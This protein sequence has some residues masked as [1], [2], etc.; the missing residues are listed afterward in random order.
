[1]KTNKNEEKENKMKIK[2]SDIIERPC[3]EYYDH[4]VNTYGKDGEFDPIEVIEKLE[5]SIY[6]MW[7]LI[8]NCKRCQTSEM[9]EYCKSLGPNY[10]SV[11][12]LIRNCKPCQTPEMLEYYKSLKPDYEG[13]GEVI[14]YC[15]FCQTEEMRKYRDSLKEKK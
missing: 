1:M 2:L 15:K 13:V 7:W 9:V 11:G 6:E 3:E 14:A 4:I 10:R 8:E 12:L 5:G